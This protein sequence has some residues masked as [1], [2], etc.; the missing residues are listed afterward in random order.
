M[1]CEACG[2]EE[3]SK[4]NVLAAKMDQ[5][6][7]GQKFIW[8]AKVLIVISKS[9]SNYVAGAQ[10]CFFPQIFCQYLGRDVIREI[11]F[12]GDI[13]EHIIDLIN[14]KDNPYQPKAGE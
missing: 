9:K 4:D 10:P 8:L 11:K 12:S 2:K 1:K 7:L 6:K 3:I 14:S 13:I 5:I